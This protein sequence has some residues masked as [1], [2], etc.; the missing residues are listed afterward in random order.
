MKQSKTLLDGKLQTIKN[1]LLRM[2]KRNMIKVITVY[3]WISIVLSLIFT[4]KEVFLELSWAQASIQS[5]A[6]IIIEYS[7]FIVGRGN[8]KK[9]TTYFN[10]FRS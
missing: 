3:F 4:V 2:S 6:E 10:I 9:Y 5:S 7:I 8:I 1:R